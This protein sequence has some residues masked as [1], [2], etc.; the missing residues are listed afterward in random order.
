MTLYRQLDWIAATR[1]KLYLFSPCLQLQP[2]LNFNLPGSALK[3]RFKSLA[4]FP[5]HIV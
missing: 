4:C 3:D 5:A 2:L 1:R